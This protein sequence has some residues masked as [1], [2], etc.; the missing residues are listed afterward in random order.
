[1]SRGN[2]RDIGDDFRTMCSFKWTSKTIRIV[3]K[4]LSMSP[5]IHCIVRI[6]Y[7][8]SKFVVFSTSKQSWV[9]KKSA[10]SSFMASLPY[11]IMASKIFLAECRPKFLMKYTKA[12]VGEIH[13]HNK[14]MKLGPYRLFLPSTTADMLEMEMN[15]M[16]GSLPT[17]WLEFA[18][19]R[20]YGHWIWCPFCLWF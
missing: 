9:S 8:V 20:E 6:F 1:M 11:T 5:Q 7:K 12:T 2:S 19:Q 13:Q 17:C 10:F 3:V 14:V 18:L 4:F 15:I 16:S